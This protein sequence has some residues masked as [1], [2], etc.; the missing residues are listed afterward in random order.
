M[1]SVVSFSLPSSLIIVIL[2]R[3]YFVH[4]EKLAMN[5]C[6]FQSI[7]NGGACTIMRDLAAIYMLLI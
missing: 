5:T 1:W 6:G 7:Q 2:K 3:F 4:V